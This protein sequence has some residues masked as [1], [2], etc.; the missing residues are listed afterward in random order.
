[1]D[2]GARLATAARRCPSGAR[3]ALLALAVGALLLATAA[4]PPVSAESRHA[5]VVG[6]AGYAVGPLPNARNDAE[7]I[8]RVLSGVGFTVTKLVDADNASLRRAVADLGRRLR[9]TGDVGLFFF[10]G[11]GLQIEGE[12]YLVP[13]GADIRQA[14]DVVVE[15]LALGEVMKA[16]DGAAGRM[17]IVILDACRNNPFVAGERTA[18][19]GLAP[20]SAP[21]GTLI[22]FAT[23][24]GKVA[25]DGDGAMSPYSRALAEAIPTPGVALEEVF[26]RARRQVIAATRGAQTPWEHSSLT[27]EFQ[28]RANTAEPEAGGRPRRAA[29]PTAQELEELRAWERIKGTTNAALIRRHLETWPNGLY[30][31]LARHKLAQLAAQAAN[32]ETIGG[33]IGTVLGPPVG[34]AEAE[35][36]FAQAMQL[37]A[38]G[39]PEA[40]ADAFARLRAAADRGLP[41]ALYRV[42]RAYDQGLGVERNLA[43]A[44]AWY[45]KAAEKG[46]GP[47]MAALGT[48]REFGDG[49]APDLAEAV[50]LYRLAAEAGNP[51]GMTSLAFLHHQGRG[52]ERD[53]GEARRWYG[54]AAEQGNVRA[55]FNLALMHVRSEGGPQDVGTAARLLQA[56]VAK[57]HAGA[58]RE[59][60]FLH[61]EGRGVARDR[62]EAARLLLAAFKAGHK[63]ARVD[64]LVRPEAWSA[65]TRREVQGLLAEA[66]HL[67]RRGS[68]TFGLETRRALEAYAKVQ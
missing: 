42:G 54:R 43:A 51:G 15:G 13:V 44:A 5:L 62:K 36:L 52:V 67:R 30:A 25:L 47:A 24:P 37:E 6:N 56:A 65:E 59:L 14:R 53:L 18:G 48:M 3:R 26:K 8:A 63:D 19:I 4:A 57:G 32:I 11:H 39:T 9:E 20:T 49:V 29:E 7:A 28:F 21:A 66:G 31:E 50:R 22:A 64:L 17:S 38:R 55:M 34:D 46:S 68:G 16:M 27:R 12:N 2:R 1:M 33:W 40:Q 23:A 60:A 10:A 58:M 61:D 41:A 35:K 45:T